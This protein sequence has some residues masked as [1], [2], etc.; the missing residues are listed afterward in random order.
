MSSDARVG[1][2]LVNLGTPA[3]PST[4]DVR[5]FL[6]EFLSDPRVLD[7]NP[8]LRPVHV[9]PNN[10][11]AVSSIMLSKVFQLGRYGEVHILPVTGYSSVNGCF[12]FLS[13]SSGSQ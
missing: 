3:S 1:V 11:V 7:M 5:R 2:L 4:G 9:F 12:Q 6:H 10:L 8:R 13:S